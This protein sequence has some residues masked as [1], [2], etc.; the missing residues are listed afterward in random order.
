ML[1]HTILRDTGAL[2]EGRAQ[3]ACVVHLSPQSTLLLH[4]MLGTTIE[5]TE[6]M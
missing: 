2:D 3:T 1:L 5:N 6:N 4:K